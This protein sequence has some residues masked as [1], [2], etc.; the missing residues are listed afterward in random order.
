MGA[1][2]PTVVGFANPGTQGILA[3][4]DQGKSLQ[5]ARIQGLP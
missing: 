3:E 2:T 5:S 4:W 1:S